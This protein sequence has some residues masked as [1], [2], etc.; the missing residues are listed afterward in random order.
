MKDF[1][2]SEVWGKSLFEGSLRESMLDLADSYDDAL[3]I[4]TETM[5]EE[6]L[7]GDIDE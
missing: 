7:E 5:V 3:H 6:V 4:E 2:K 1:P